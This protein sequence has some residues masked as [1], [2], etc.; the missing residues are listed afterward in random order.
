VTGEEQTTAAYHLLAP[1]EEQRREC[2]RDI[3]Q[4]LERVKRTA[5]ITRAFR[6]NSSKEGKRKLKRYLSAAVKFCDAYKVLPLAAKP[7][8]NSHLQQAIEREISVATGLLATRPVNRRERQRKGGLRDT[9]LKRAAV[10]GAYILLVW[11]GHRPTTTQEGQWERLSALLASVEEDV[12]LFGLLREFING[13]APAIYAAKDAADNIVRV[14]NG[15][16]TRP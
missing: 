9:D 1:P 5:S 16:N 12:T 11:Y 10:E 3:E 4:I 15:S 6:Q 8:F 7:W 14:V 13:P 2:R